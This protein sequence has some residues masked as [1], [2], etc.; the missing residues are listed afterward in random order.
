MS[1][2]IPLAVILTDIRSGMDPE[3]ACMR[4]GVRLEYL[5]PVYS[6][7]MKDVFMRYLRGCLELSEL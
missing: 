2:D 1:K 7:Y 4:H 5:N 3:D 6:Q